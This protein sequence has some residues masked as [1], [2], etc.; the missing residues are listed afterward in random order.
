[1]KK[2]INLNQNVGK[3]LILKFEKVWMKKGKTALTIFDEK[4]VNLI[5]NFG[6]KNILKF[7]DTWRQLTKIKLKVFNRKNTKVDSKQIK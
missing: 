3:K 7:V 6:K 1:M 4:S 2:S 5:Q